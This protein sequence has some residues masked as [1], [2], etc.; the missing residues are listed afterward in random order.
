MNI[1]LIAH[2]KKKDLMVEFCLAYKSVLAKHTLLATGITGG[3]I[4]E[5]TGLKVNRFLPGREGGSE[6]IAARIAYNEIDMV[7][8]FRDPF[9]QSYE[10]DMQS[11]LKLCDMHTVPLA[12]NVATAE[13]LIHS[14]S[15]GDLDYRTIMRENNGKF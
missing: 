11:L 12:T 7:L 13:A 10:P 1:A 3:L 2:D 9:A 4:E 8:S 15:R 14:L 5:A 6:Q